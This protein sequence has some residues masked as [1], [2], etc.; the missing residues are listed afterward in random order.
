[1]KKAQRMTYE[2][3]TTI[4]QL[5][6]MGLNAYR[7][8]KKL[9]IPASVARYHFNKFKVPVKQQPTATVT[10][11]AEPTLKKENE[12]LKHLNKSLVDLVSFYLD[13]YSVQ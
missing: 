9:G 5:K 6:E 1:M 2:Q 4:K 3:L 10:T 11:V 7:I 8:A 13:S 12:K